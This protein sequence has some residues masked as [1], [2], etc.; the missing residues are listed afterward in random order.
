MGG[1]ISVH[2]DTALIFRSMLLGPRG[3]IVE[4]FDITLQP[5]TA[6]R[7][8]ARKVEPQQDHKVVF[9][10]DQQGETKT[11]KRERRKSDCSSFEFKTWRNYNI[12]ELR[13]SKLQANAIRV[14]E[15]LQLSGLVRE[16]LMG[17]RIEDREAYGVLYRRCFIANELVTY[18]VLH[19]IATSKEDAV[20]M[21]RR[22]QDE[23][24]FL[25]M[26]SNA[27]FD[28]EFQFFKVNESHDV[29]HRLGKLKKAPATWDDMPMLAFAPHLDVSHLAPSPKNY[30]NR[31]VE[32]WLEKRSRLG[33]Y[34]MRFFRIIPDPKD[35]KHS[36]ITWHSDQVAL[37][38]SGSISSKDIQTVLRPNPRKFIIEV[39]VNQ[40]N[41]KS[42]LTIRAPN[43][44]HWFR[45][46]HAIQSYAKTLS[47]EDVIKHSALAHIMDE[48]QMRDFSKRLNI[49]SMKAG[50]VIATRGESLQQFYI[51]SSGKIGIFLSSKDKKEVQLTTRCR[52]D[53][54]G[55]EVCTSGAEPSRSIKAL[56]DCVLL[57]ISEKERLSFM[58]KH[59]S[60]N[61]AFS[62][63][64]HSDL[65]YCIETASIFKYLNVSQRERL[66]IGLKYRSF[67]PKDTVYRVNS[68]GDAIYIVLN[69]ELVITEYDLESRTDVVTKRLGPND[70]IG[71]LCGF[72]KGAPRTE[73]VSASKN[74]LVLMLDY[75]TLENF[76]K[77]TGLPRT[78][79][80][81][82]MVL[83]ILNNSKASFF[84]G[85][86]IPAMRKLAAK[87]CSIEVFNEGSN[88]FNEGDTGNK[89]YTIIIGSV[90]ISVGGEVVNRLGVGASFGEISLVL[91]NTLRTATVTATSETAFLTIDKR[92]FRK[93]FS[94]QSENMASIEL[95]IAG[96]QCQI[97][98]IVYHP[99]GYQYFSKFLEA[100]G[101]TESAQFWKQ[102]REYRL[103]AAPIDL[104]D[105]KAVQARAQDIYK[106]FIESKS[107]ALSQDVAEEIK[108]EISGG[109]I[110]ATT[111]VR[112]ENE[113]LKTMSK[114]YLVQFKSSQ[115]FEHLMGLVEGYSVTKETRDQGALVR[116][117]S[118]LHSR[119]SSNSSI[120]S[121]KRSNT[122]FSKL[123]AVDLRVS[124]PAPFFSQQ[125]I[126]EEKEAEV[127]ALETYGSTS[128]EEILTL[129]SSRNPSICSPVTSKSLRAIKYKPNS[130]PRSKSNKSISI[131]KPKSPSV[132]SPKSETL[133]LGQSAADL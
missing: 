92:A 14:M 126:T 27:K 46:F 111:F 56:T 108:T 9:R 63:M 131:G 1:S 39:K 115:W 84:E 65:E 125:M 105:N 17:V 29:V 88:I 78:V 53:F 67:F 119:V 32:G 24:V 90:E 43:T 51:I 11:T 117:G 118:R 66:C 74:S 55:E 20:K 109:D 69:G 73:D 85:L 86:P 93:F 94:T 8:D 19:R 38:P 82:N 103:W 76:F 68:P 96:N 26:V 120:V 121:M 110:D 70:V 34:K 25:P 42:K 44:E 60:V 113:T 87:H 127:R 133:N 6:V 4:G 61:K 72:L 124:K 71:E 5:G 31:Q 36:I 49:V 33:F 37:K 7:V 102:L 81:N 21:C 89:F 116:G 128:R 40:G 79:I 97:R 15:N 2:N 98:S 47:P 18:L 41:E 50:T 52:F 48:K 99:K 101:D 91:E 12:L 23:N 45:W 122:S 28:N 83:D 95:K 3:T 100:N 35:Y 132:T 54:L 112:A 80:L 64:F 30:A 129:A 16:V 57:T 59:Q 130:D 58:K 106:R 123:S 13:V 22:L 10:M 107:V 114:K 104:D 77:L 75:D 62:A